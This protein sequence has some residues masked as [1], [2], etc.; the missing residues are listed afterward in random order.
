MEH[1]PMAWDDEF[2]ED[3]DPR[4]AGARSRA[5]TRDGHAVRRAAGFTGLVVGAVAGIVALA[6]GAVV[7]V[8]AIG[9]AV[10]PDG[11]ESLTADGPHIGLPP[12]TATP[13]DTEAA[14]G[15]PVDGDASLPV[16]LDA[17]EGVPYEPG[18]TSVD[19][20]WMTRIAAATGIP[21][22]ALSAYAA[23]HVAIAIEDPTCG[24][25]WATIA[26]IGD[27]ESDHGRHG[28]STLDAAGRATPPIVGRA[29]DGDGVAKIP[30]TDGGALDGDPVWD[31]AVGPMQFIPS[32]WARWAAD[33]DGD[34]F[35][36]PHQIDDAALTTAR[37]LCA[38]GSMTTSDGWR[39]AIY[40]YNHDNDYVAKVASVA[41]GFAA[42]I[43]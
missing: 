34:G 11:F 40:S 24:L 3:V 13:E 15:E 7:A 33:A 8:T 1:G 32:T 18:V 10:R 9:T 22:R 2:D 12:R 26:A 31:R 28:D 38:A 14:S 21:E 39:R 17:T 6:V 42:A 25:D 16:P 36:D 37:Y 20:G 23:A 29:L 35:A 43:R 5:A 27:I 41:H 30:D 4:P 19:E